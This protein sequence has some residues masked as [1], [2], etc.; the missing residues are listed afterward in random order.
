MSGGEAHGTIC[1]TTGNKYLKY[2][3]EQWYVGLQL[4]TVPLLEL[5]LR[6][7][8]SMICSAWFLGNDR[9][10]V[11]VDKTRFSS[12]SPFLAL[13]SQC[14]LLP[15]LPLWCVLVTTAR[16]L[17]ICLSWVWMKFYHFWQLIPWA[18][19][20]PLCSAFIDDFSSF[21]LTLFFSGSSFKLGFTILWECLK[22]FLLPFFASRFHQDF[23]RNQ[24]CEI[25][26]CVSPLSYWAKNRAIVQSFEALASGLLFPTEDSLEIGDVPLLRRSVSLSCEFWVHGKLSLFFRMTPYYVLLY[27]HRWFGP[28]VASP[29]TYFTG[30][31]CIRPLMHH[32]HLFYSCWNTTRPVECGVKTQNMLR[33]WWT[34]LPGVDSMTRNWKAIQ[35]RLKQCLTLWRV[36]LEMLRTWSSV[37]RAQ[38]RPPRW[39]KLSSRYA[40]AACVLAAILIN[41]W[42]RRDRTCAWAM[43]WSSRECVGVPSI[44]CAPRIISLAFLL[45]QCFI[46]SSLKV[47]T[48][49][50]CTALSC[51]MAV[52]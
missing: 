38:E 14:T 46:S 3:S 45:E 12:L 29:P 43:P 17:R 21:L 28:F 30:E 2:K 49:S 26:F 10:M 52:A 50:N 7:L 51:S 35:S 47:N 25:E 9:S 20:L 33:F 23:I 42:L 32:L 18:P 1:P 24:K 13:Q 15:T 6:R 11:I 16:T 19:S 34:L 37:R 27:A 8:K 4:K 31:W 41:S 48:S 40:R 5:I 22:D 44:P 39:W 36:P